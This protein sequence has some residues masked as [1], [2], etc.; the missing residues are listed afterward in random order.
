MDDPCCQL[1]RRADRRSAVQPRAASRRR[2]CA[3][4]GR[5]RPTAIAGS[6]DWHLPLWL[7]S[8]LRRAANTDGKGTVRSSSEDF[9]ALVTKAI[10]FAS[11]LKKRKPPLATCNRLVGDEL[12][13]MCVQNRARRVGPKRGKSVG[14]AEGTRNSQDSDA[15]EDSSDR[16]PSIDR[17]V[18]RIQREAKDVAPETRARLCI[19]VRS[20]LDEEGR[21]APAIYGDA[22]AGRLWAIG[23]DAQQGSS[24]AVRARA[25]PGSMDAQQF[26][27][28]TLIESG[29]SQADLYDAL[30]APLVDTV[31][32]GGVCYARR[33]HRLKSLTDA[34]W[35]QMQD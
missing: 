17:S 33:P 10:A 31:R 4:P 6:A 8:S 13:E 22:A 11:A 23:S 28:D 3:L 27:C 29:G 12:L 16:S 5:P 30:G 25:Q 34:R 14:T 9:R 35:Q 19:R 7:P 20:V 2:A 24:N 15:R 18:A 32:A 1:R 21:A 26:S